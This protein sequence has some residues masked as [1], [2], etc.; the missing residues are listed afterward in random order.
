MML[1]QSS[2]VTLSCLLIKHYYGHPQSLESLGEVRTLTFFGEEK[3][4][5]HA[6]TEAKLLK[7]YLKVPLYFWVENKFDIRLFTIY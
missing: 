3:E 4:I 6:W 7:S 5:H 2:S 1:W